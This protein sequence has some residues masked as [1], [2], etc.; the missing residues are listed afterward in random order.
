MAAV[1]SCENRQLSLSR[2]ET[3]TTTHTRHILIWRPTGKS[4]IKTNRLA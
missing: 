2:V 3:G 4:M 1:T